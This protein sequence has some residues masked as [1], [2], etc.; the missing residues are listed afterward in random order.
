MYGVLYAEAYIKLTGYDKN[1]QIFL[2]ILLILR[3]TG[4]YLKFSRF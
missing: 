4:R 1:S 2:H 3:L